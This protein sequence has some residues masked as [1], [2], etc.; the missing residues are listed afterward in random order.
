MAYLFCAHGFHALTHWILFPI[1]RK[2]FSLLL[3]MHC[4]F[5]WVIH[6]VPTHNIIT[7][8]IISTKA[9][10]T[11]L[12]EESW[13]KWRQSYSGPQMSPL[14]PQAWPCILTASRTDR[15]GLLGCREERLWGTCIN[16]STLVSSSK[17][18]S[19]NLHTRRVSW[20]LCSMTTCVKPPAAQKKAH[21]CWRLYGWPLRLGL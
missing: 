10:F 4:L 13:L 20:F 8:Y 21:L 3:A 15:A 18:R 17:P 16:S 11:H 9:Y 5:F 6:T 2:S 14:H 1:M 19:S 12:L 7:W